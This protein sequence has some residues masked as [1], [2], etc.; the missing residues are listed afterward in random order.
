M[1]ETP[2]IP[3]SLRSFKKTQ[4]LVRQLALGILFGLAALILVGFVAGDLLLG[5]VLLAV[6]F[7]MGL[8]FAVSRSI[9]V[10]QED[11]SDA[12]EIKR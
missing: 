12:P 5:L 11:D 9:S 3:D 8:L 7:V 6:I 10:L 1:N 2:E 4:R